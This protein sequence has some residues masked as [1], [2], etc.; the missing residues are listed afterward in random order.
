MIYQIQSIKIKTGNL[1]TINKAL[2]QVR[3]IQS[4]LNGRDYS[5]DNHA[6]WNPT[7]STSFHTPVTRWIE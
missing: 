3:H 1:P 2:L 6:L 7:H 4:R 5:A